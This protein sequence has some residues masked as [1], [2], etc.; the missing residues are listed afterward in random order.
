MPKSSYRH[1]AKQT[2]VVIV[3][4]VVVMSAILAGAAYLGVK[5]NFTQ[6]TQQGLTPS[7]CTTNSVQGVLSAYPSSGSLSSPAV[8]YFISQGGNLIQSPTGYGTITSGS[9]YGPSTNTFSPGYIAEFSAS[10]AYPLWV[11]T[12]GNG[13][14]VTSNGIEVYSLKCQQNSPGATA[15]QAY[16]WS[17]SA[18]LFSAPSSGTSATTNV[19][20]VA[21]S[22]AGTSLVAATQLPSSPL[23]I[24]FLLNI[25][26]ANTAAMLPT[27]VYGTAANPETTYSNGGQT[28]SES[29]PLQ[30]QGYLLVSVNQTG[31]SFSGVGSTQVIPITVNTVTSGTK[32][33]LIP[34]SGCGPSSASTSSSSVDTCVTASV[35][36]GET[37]SAQGKHI[38]I[39]GIFVDMQ[40]A[41]YI[42]ANFANPAVTAFPSAGS[43]AGVPTGFT[44]LTPTTG[45][46]SANP[47]PLIEQSVTVIMSY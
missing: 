19:E 33:W 31:I 9:K 23:Q 28:V 46:N 32:A 26:S 18:T 40:Q 29:A 38:A 35:S 6:P 2:T 17:E 22:P 12:T 13:Q 39:T 45:Q 41:A 30:V 11:Q 42:E 25:L 4:A 5:L 47:S 10:G 7:G 24:N 16:V 15:G 1:L 43:A 37:V 20:A 34:V 14:V 36:I 44:F 8:T 21:Q 3:V 27:T